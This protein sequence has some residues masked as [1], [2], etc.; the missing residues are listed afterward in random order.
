MTSPLVS[1]VM[2]TYNHALYVAKAIDSVLQQRGVDF[3]FLIADDGS[4][5]ATAQV[6]ESVRD[7]R[8]RFFPHQSNRG[9]CIVINELIEQ[10]SG[11]FVALINSDDYWISPDKLAFQL[12]IMRANPEL[13]AC[14]GR[15][16]FVNKQGRRLKKSE[17]SFGTVFDQGNRSQGAWLRHFFEAGNAICH[18][19]MLIRRR[20]YK[21][22]GAYNNNLRQLPDFDLWVRLVKRYPINITEHELIDFRVLPK[23]SASSQTGKN[24]VRIMN[25]HYLIA[26][27]FFDGVSAQQLKEGFADLLKHPDLPSEIHVD[28]EKALL[29]LMPFRGLGRAYNMIGLLKLN[30]L[31]VS[32]AHQRVLA[33]DYGI[34]GRWFQ[35]RTVEIDVLRPLFFAILSQ[36]KYR[37]SWFFKRLF[38][39]T[40][41]V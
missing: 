7:P 24:S 36:Q 14:F 20:C 30:R 27:K 29:L 10:A 26:E 33:E 39:F 15:A 31:L 37:L 6:V 4:A 3:E 32:D 34:D 40:K 25:E 18:P 5:D 35:A 22:L 23:E 2:A 1:V 9:A 21:E 8:I 28:I 13:G 12:D 16:H 41:R 17:V 19:T 11:E 38:A